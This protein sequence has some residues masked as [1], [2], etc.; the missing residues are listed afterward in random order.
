MISTVYLLHEQ[1]KHIQYCT[2]S[3]TIVTVVS[4]Y[5]VGDSFSLRL[6]LTHTLHLHFLSYPLRESSKLNH[7][8]ILCVLYSAVCPQDRC[9]RL[10]LAAPERRK[11]CSLYNCFTCE[12]HY[13][14]MYS[15]HA[16][17]PFIMASVSVW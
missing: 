13:V 2:C 9:T 3:I 11:L 7:P 15:K 14:Y 1:N 16:N 17:A 6:F 8:F 4:D 5:V 10:I 12:L